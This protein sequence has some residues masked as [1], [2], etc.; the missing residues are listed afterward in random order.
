[1]GQVANLRPGPKGA[2]NRPLDFPEHSAEMELRH[3]TEPVKLI[4]RWRKGRVMVVDKQNLIEKIK[5]TEFSCV[6][7][8]EAVDALVGDSMQ[9]K[10]IAEQAKL[11]EA[12]IS[13]FHACYRN[14]RGVA[15]ECAGK[16]LTDSAA[17]LL[18]KEGTGVEQQ[19]AIFRRA[20][21]IAKNRQDSQKGKP[22]RRNPPGNIT[23]DDMK[24]AIRAHK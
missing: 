20:Q 2:P 12:L 9:K 21:Q 6:E 5:S 23:K 15:R 14:L 13:N 7:R 10:R 4:L 1:M 18:A 17:Y 16:T 22:G 8:G 24:A 11:S 19:D 3:C